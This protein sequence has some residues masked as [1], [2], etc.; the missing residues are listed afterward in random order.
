MGVLRLMF[1]AIQIP[2]PLGFYFPRWYTDPLYRG[3]F[4][5][6][7]ASFYPEHHENLRA[8][9]AERLWFAGEATS[10]K[11]FGKNPFDFL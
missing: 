11:Y 2:D 5:N 8:T 6:W 9:V 10:K 4:S 3:A 7:P 1:P